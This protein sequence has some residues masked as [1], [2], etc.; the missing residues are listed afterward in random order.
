LID[1]ARISYAFSMTF[2]A[3]RVTPLQEERF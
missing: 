2:R 3:T 1:V